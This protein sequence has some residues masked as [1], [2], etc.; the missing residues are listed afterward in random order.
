MHADSLVPLTTAPDTTTVAS[1]VSLSVSTAS[2]AS[3]PS[4]DSVRDQS[5]RLYDLVGWTR[6]FTDTVTVSPGRR[7]IR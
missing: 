6:L 2:Q 5:S 3:P 7:V 4:V 1:A